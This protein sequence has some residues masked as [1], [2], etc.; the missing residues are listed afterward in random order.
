[1]HFNSVQVLDAA[2]SGTVRPAVRLG[3]AFH[4]YIWYGRM[5]ELCVAGEYYQFTTG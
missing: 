5:E 1:M 2:Q 3:I 4:R